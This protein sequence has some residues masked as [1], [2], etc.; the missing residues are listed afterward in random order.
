MTQPATVNGTSKTLGSDEL[1]LLTK[2]ARMY[3]ERGIRQHRIAA[4]L[5]MSQSRVS[6]LLQQAAEMG[7]V[8]TTV[9]LPA[10]VYPAMEEDLKARYNL[11]DSVIVDADGVSGDLSRAL[12]AAA[13]TYLRET[14]SSGDIVG[15]SSGSIR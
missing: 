6:R 13:A 9:T 3:H 1:R 10:G 7:I 2:I 5:H 8:R 4:Q 14:L 12:G 15:I 11:L